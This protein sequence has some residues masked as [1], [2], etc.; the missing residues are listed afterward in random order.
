MPRTAQLVQ[1]VRLKAGSQGSALSRKAVWLAG[2]AFV[3]L[4]AVPWVASAAGCTT[5]WKGPV[6]GSWQTPADWSSGTVPTSSDVACIGVGDVVSVT[7]GSNQVGV[8]LD[9]GGLTISK[10]TLEVVGTSE[11]S[12]VEALSVLG[13]RWLGRGKCW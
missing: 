1:T 7:E 10:G 11:A 9:E 4:L 2:M 6:E 5:T 12:S 3:V 13:A 8:V